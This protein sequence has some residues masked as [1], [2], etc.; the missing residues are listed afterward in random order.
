MTNL[1][2]RSPLEGLTQLIGRRLVFCYVNLRDVRPS[3]EVECDFMREVYQ[4]V[5][6]GLE[7]D[8][9]IFLK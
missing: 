6:E 3:A 4:K 2:T 8:G 1:I 5:Y 7:S 9:A